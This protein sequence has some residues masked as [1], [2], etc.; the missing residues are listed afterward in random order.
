[1]KFL[2]QQNLSQ[3]SISDNTILANTYGRVVIDASGGL[4]LP[5]G[6]TAQR[7][8]TDG[9]RQP[10]NA[11][12]TIR[13]NVETN[14]IEA[15]IYN[16]DTGNPGGIW[17]AVKS[18]SKTVIKKQ[19]LGP[20]D[21][22]ET[23]FG[24]LIEK[25]ANDDNILV[26]VENVLQISVTNFNVVYSDGSDL[27]VGPNAPYPEG[28]YIKF[29]QPVPATNAGSSENIYITVYHGFSN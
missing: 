20:G 8:Q 1:M 19:T 17:E 29:T 2:K 25:P 18:S 28:W 10:T 4:L 7:P 9:V 5:K 23:V 26:L 15:Y 12:G 22:T 24:P 27:S 3:F 6:T 21:G 14:N 11:Y 13:Y 16:E